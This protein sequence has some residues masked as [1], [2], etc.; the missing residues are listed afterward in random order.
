MKKQSVTKTQL[1]DRR[2]RKS[3]P[4]LAETLSS[5]IREPAWHRVAV[6]LSGP[7]RQYAS[8]NLFQIDQA[9]KDGETVIVVGKV[10]SQGALTK[11]IT[12]CG[13]S[14]SATAREKLQK[15]GSQ[16][17]T[18]RDAMKKYPKA[19]GVKLL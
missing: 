18:L 17:M 8:L 11:K 15:S 2:G 1:K 16:F 12:V 9:A 5:A 7:T 19:E 14:I 4:I 6:R 13:L 3:N 10:L